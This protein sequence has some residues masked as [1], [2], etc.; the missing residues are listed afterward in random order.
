MKFKSGILFI[1]ML[2]CFLAIGHAQ[3]IVYSEP[4]K[5]DSRKVDFEIIGK[6]G[7]NFQ[8]YKNIRNSSFV[9]LYDQEMKQIGKVEQDYIPDER[10]INL[11]V[12]PYAEHSYLFYQYQ[13]RSVVYF[14]AAKIGADGKKIGDPVALDTTHLNFAAN[15]KVYNCI[16]SED[17]SKFLIFKIN[18]RN[19]NNYVITTKLLNDQLELIKNSQINM[20]MDDRNDY[21][22]E[23]KLDNAGNMVFVK[24]NR[25]SNDNISAVSLFIKPAMADSFSNQ[26]LNLN[27]TYLDQMFIKVDNFNNRYFLTSFYYKQRRGNIDGLYFYVWDNATSQPSMEKSI[28][29]G[30]ELRFEA[31]GNSGNRYAFDNY[32]IRNLIIKKNGGFLLGAESY[33]TT[34]RFNNWNRWD[35]LYGFPSMNALDY[36]YYSPYSYGYNN[37]WWRSR[38]N[39]QSVRHHAENVILLSFDSNGGLEWNNVIKKEQFDDESDNLVS[40]Q[41]VNT[42]GALHFIYN[43]MEKRAVLLTDLVLEPGGKITRNSRLKNIDKGYSFM[44]KYG[45]QVSSSQVIIPCMY[46]NY[47]CFAKIDF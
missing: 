42:G 10:L 45:K 15:N 20:P 18:S 29:F 27:N 21:L 23:F 33:Y 47:I 17:K 6:I 34:S 36:Y 22:D 4:E 24:F 46:R 13:R 26:N 8:V 1:G 41:L 7:D 14:M 25:G 19:K 30:D 35:Y 38:N 3:K 31:K 39:N 40:F 5:D 16:T 12:F 11:D 28:S 43:L 2:C 9:V 44:P 32:F 37:L